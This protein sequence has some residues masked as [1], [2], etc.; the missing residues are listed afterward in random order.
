MAILVISLAFSAGHEAEAKKLIGTKGAVQ[1][2]LQELLKKQRH[3]AIS[4]YMKSWCI[5]VLTQK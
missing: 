1:G 2:S 4:F 3:L 5:I